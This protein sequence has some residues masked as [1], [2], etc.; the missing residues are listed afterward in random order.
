MELHTNFR[1]IPEPRRVVKDVFRI[2]SNTQGIKVTLTRIE[3]IRDYYSVYRQHDLITN[4]IAYTD[5][6]SQ[7]CSVCQDGTGCKSL[8][9]WLNKEISNLDKIAGKSAPAKIQLSDDKI[10]EFYSNKSEFYSCHT[11]EHVLELLNL[12]IGLD[13]KQLCNDVFIAKIEKNREEEKTIY[14]KNRKS[15]DKSEN[16]EENSTENS[17]EESTSKET[18]TK[19]TYPNNLDSNIESPSKKCKQNDNYKFCESSSSSSS[20]PLTPMSNIK[21]DFSNMSLGETIKPDILRS[22]SSSWANPLIEAIKVCEPVVQDEPDVQIV[23]VT[24][25]DN[26]FNLEKEIELLQLDL[27]SFSKMVRLESLEMLGNLITETKQ[28]IST[29]NTESKSNDENPDNSKIVYGNPQYF[30][31]FDENINRSLN[32]HANDYKVFAKNLIQIYPTIHPKYRDHKIRL[33]VDFKAR[34]DFINVAQKHFSSTT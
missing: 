24:Q 26:K 13:A 33:L 22:V 17:D 8:V 11:R 10:L 15:S 20:K 3:P 1:I 19:R 30:K 16:S 9:T 29:T 23:S 7:K 14:G 27:E 18:G 32:K 2:G 12:L 25:V 31:I 34:N 28:Q 21:N 4:I 5:Y 6:F